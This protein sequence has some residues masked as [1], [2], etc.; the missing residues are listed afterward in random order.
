MLA[1]KSINYA[2][3]IPTLVVAGVCEPILLTE[4]FLL[5]QPGANET[6]KRVRA[7][8]LV[9]SSAST[10]TTERL[11]ADKGSRCLAICKRLDIRTIHME[12]VRLTD[13]EVS[14]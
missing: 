8:S 1:K 7:T 11:L 13:I 9:V 2:F 5:N 12:T 4:E 14:G 10:S 6:T 3:Y